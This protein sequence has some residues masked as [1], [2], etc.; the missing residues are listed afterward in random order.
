MS[1]DEA[2]FDSVDS[3]Q[4]QWC[5]IGG[6]AALVLGIAYIVI[7][8]LYAHV[9]APPSGGEPWLKYLPGKTAVWW[10]ILGLC[11]YGLSLCTGCVRPL[12]GVEQDQPKRDAASDSIR[13]AVR[14][15]RSGNH[16]V[17]LRLSARSL[18][19]LLQGYR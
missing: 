6:I 10:A 1:P 5:R 18:W 17:A 16:L 14:R 12:P 11:V 4:R 9:G 19:Q 7:I 2:S 13:R 3:D 8:P 15:L